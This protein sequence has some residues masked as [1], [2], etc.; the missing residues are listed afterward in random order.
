MI[1]LVDVTVQSQSGYEY[2][3]LILR[4]G[5]SPLRCSV[6]QQPRVPLSSQPRTNKPVKAIFWPWL[7]PFSVQK[8]LKSWGHRF[9]VVFRGSLPA[10]RV[11][12]LQSPTHSHSHSHTHS[13]T[14]THSLSRTLTHT[15]SHSHTHTLTHSHTLSR[16]HSLTLTHTLAGHK[17]THGKSCSA[18]TSQRSAS[19][20]C[21]ST[22]TAKVDRISVGRTPYPYRWPTIG[23]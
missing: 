22:S 16:T 14:H 1:L 15:H 2:L 13:H 6:P 7:E 21:K 4:G 10:F 9:G 3:R 20:A 12:R 17:Y 8:H 11:A 18:A 19:R 23:S 5:V